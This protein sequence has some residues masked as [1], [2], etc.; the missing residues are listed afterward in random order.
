M[1]IGDYVYTPRFGTVQI[2]DVFKSK[3]EA[4]KN[5]Y[6]EPTYYEGEYEVLGKSLALNQMSFAA[7]KNK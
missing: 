2:K 7:I 6:K 5:G 3:K 1:K 4:V